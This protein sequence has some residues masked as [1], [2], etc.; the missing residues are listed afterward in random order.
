MAVSIIAS[1]VLAG[2]IGEMEH[3]LDRVE[4]AAGERIRSEMNKLASSMTQRAETAA[5]QLNILES[6]FAEQKECTS[7]EPA[8][9]PAMKA[10]L[11]F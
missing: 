5:R 3:D 10:R 11:G 2:L 4:A 1:E 8:R 6:K 9:T 7:A